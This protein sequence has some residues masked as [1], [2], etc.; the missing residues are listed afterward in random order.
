MREG[1]RV[2]VRIASTAAGLVLVLGFGVLNALYLLSDR[3]DAVPGLYSYVSSTLGD[4]VLL[5]TLTFVLVRVVVDRDTGSRRTRV[6]ML[7]GGVIGCAL[8]VALQVT[9][10][11]DPDPILNWTL[12]AAGVFNAAGWYHAVFL[13][14][15]SGFLGA[16][17]MGTA[18]IVLAS[19]EAW[20]ESRVSVI[21][22]TVCVALFSVALLIDNLSRDLRSSSAA[23]LGAVALCGVVLVAATIA[24]WTIRRKGG[25]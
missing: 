25:R 4:A 18:S 8:G 23:T 7:A 16:L 21:L 9:W 10:L 15:V 24:I 20:R 5:P 19:R 2:G 1:D 3:S 6:A 14:A 11:L 17:A 13:T 22:A 12:P